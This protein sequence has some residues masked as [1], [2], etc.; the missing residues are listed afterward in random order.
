MDNNRMAN[1]LFRLDA[2]TQQTDRLH[3]EVLLLPRISHSILITLLL[4]WLL[5]VAIWL[6]TSTYARKETVAGW[7]EPPSGVTRVYAEDTGIIKQVLVTE[8]DA[9]VADQ[10]LIIVNGDRILADGEHLE[11]RLL[12]EYESQRHLLNEQ[13]TRTTGI[14]QRRQQD[15]TQRIAA[16]EQDLILLGEQFVT[17]NERHLLIQT[18]VERYR[19]LRREGHVSSLEFDN[20][21]AQ[22]LALRN[23]RQALLREQVNRRNLIQ[24]LHTEQELLPEEHANTIDQLRARLSD[25]AQQIAQLHGQRA[26]I[27]KASRAGIVNNLQAREGQQAHSGSNIPLLTLIPV[28]TQLTAQLLIPVRSAGFIVPGQALDIRYDAFPY[29]KF[30]LYR[31]KVISISDTVLLPNEVLNAAVIIQEPVYRVTAYLQQATVQ[32]YGQ[33]FS[34][35]PGMTLSAD[36]RLGE[37]S[38]V[39]W[40]LEPIYSLKGRL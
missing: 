22:E 4:L 20:A 40:L 35:K 6:V 21:M 34:L 37:R 28:D 31:G 14:F 23:D 17:L 8:G 32:A 3:G 10:P 13:L 5:A 25:I 39:Q 2:I 15:I 12:N 19:T 27:I 1:G 24:Q 11:H 7:L 26:H 38:L 9:V 33:D 36:V 16:A 18:Q 29:Q 30:G